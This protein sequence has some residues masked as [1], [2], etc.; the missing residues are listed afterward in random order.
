MRYSKKG[1]SKDVSEDTGEL[2]HEFR[3]YSLTYLLSQCKD[4]KEQKTDLEQ[5]CDEISCDIPNFVSVLFTPK[6]HCELAGEGI[7]YSW[8]ASKRYYRR[9]PITMKRSSVNF[10][11]L[12]KDSINKVSTMMCRK[13]SRK[14]RGYMLGY[15]HKQLQKE[16]VGE[17]I[18]ES[19]EYNE[20]IHKMYRGHRDANCIDGAFIERVMLQCTSIVIV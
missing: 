1:E 16:E 9:Q 15:R 2:L 10:E 11:R 8:G 4:F 18:K 6:F 17:D 7:E 5:L 19:Y 13:F 12:M 20:K 14:A 3:K